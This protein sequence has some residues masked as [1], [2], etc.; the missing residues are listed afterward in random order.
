MI[1]WREEGG[2]GGHCHSHLLLLNISFI[3]ILIGL[4]CCINFYLFIY[5]F[6]EFPN[7]KQSSNDAAANVSRQLHSSCGATTNQ[8]DCRC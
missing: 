8:Q 6:A 7:I 1:G 3:F 4:Q 2:W 5:L